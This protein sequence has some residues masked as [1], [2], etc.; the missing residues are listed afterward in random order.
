MERSAA[1]T[2]ELDSKLEADTVEGICQHSARLATL[3]DTSPQIM[4]LVSAT[5][6]CLL[7]T[8]TAGRVVTFACQVWHVL[9][10]EGVLQTPSGCLCHAEGSCMLCTWL[11]P[12][13]LDISS[14]RR[15]AVWQTG[16]FVWHAGAAPWERTPG[17]HSTAGIPSQHWQPCGRASCCQLR[18][19]LCLTH[20]AMFKL[21]QWHL[22]TRAAHVCNM[23]K[24]SSAG[25]I[26][27]H[28][29]DIV[30]GHD[31]PI[32]QGIFQWL[33]AQIAILPRLRPYSMRGQR[34]FHLVTSARYPPWN[35]SVI[36]PGCA[37]R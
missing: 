6:M 34:L 33:L 29:L 9:L 2:A 10:G 11:Q 19:L 24:V 3:L 18:L 4:Q 26:W 12:T 37:S 7:S 21:L 17:R 8:A 28:F 16:Y 25:N 13:R 1:A 23:A 15:I 32:V 14:S 22:L 31:G 35:R 36:A 20:A 30:F 5:C 27:S